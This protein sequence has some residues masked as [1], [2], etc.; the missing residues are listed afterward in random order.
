M[1]NCDETVLLAVILSINC[2]SPSL[3]ETAAD[4]LVSKETEAAYY[5]Q[6]ANNRI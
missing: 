5:F 2:H 6:S 3:K 1:E 4:V